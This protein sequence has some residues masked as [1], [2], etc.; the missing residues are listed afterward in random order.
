MTNRIM[1]D[2]RTMEILGET[3]P[4]AIYGLM[5]EFDDPEVLLHATQAAHDAG[6]RKMDAYT[7][8][9]VH[10]MEDALGLRRSRLPILVLLGAIAGGLA[11]YGLEYWA[12]VI[13]YPYNVAGRP[14]HSW[15]LFMPVAFET[16]V[17]GAAFAAVFGMLGRNGLPQPYHPVFNTPGFDLASRNQFYLCIESDDPKFDPIGTQHFLE[18]VRSRKVSEVEF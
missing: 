8:F 13:N 10:G 18:S 2:P 7:P 17:L 5:A 6:Y 11:G 4:R 1:P 14:L 9:P 12:S 3:S 15:I 16:T